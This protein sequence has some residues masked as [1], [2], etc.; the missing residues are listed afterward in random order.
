VLQA[1]RTLL[2]SDPERCEIC[3]QAPKDSP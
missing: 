3:E 1:L 2:K